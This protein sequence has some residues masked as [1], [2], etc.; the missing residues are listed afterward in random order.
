[1]AISDNKAVIGALGEDSA[2]TGVNGNQF[3]NSAENAGAAYVFKRKDFVNFSTWSQEAYLKASNTEAVDV[4]GSSVRS[5]VTPSSSLL[6]SKTATPPGSMAT[7]WTI[8]PKP[9]GPR[10]YSLRR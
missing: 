3:D 2:A 6:I 4:F 1:V 10:M 5:R 7:N 8:A 9:P